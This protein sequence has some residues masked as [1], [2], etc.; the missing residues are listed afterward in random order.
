MFRED[1]F[2]FF[3]FFKS[4]CFEL[5]SLCNDNS[6]EVLSCGESATI[7]RESETLSFAE[8]CFSFAG[9]SDYNSESRRGRFESVVEA[10]HHQTLA[11]HRHLIPVD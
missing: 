6:Q 8:C 10:V 9:I 11:S 5:E 3:F 7:S 1:P 2:F 4:R